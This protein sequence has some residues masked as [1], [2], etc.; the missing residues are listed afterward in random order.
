MLPAA[1]VIIIL[2]TT[3]EESGLHIPSS[4]H[5]ELLLDGENPDSSQW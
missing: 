5:S 4:P 3:C 1:A 2:H